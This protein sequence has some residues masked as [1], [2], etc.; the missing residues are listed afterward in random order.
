VSVPPNPF[1]TDVDP[2]HRYDALVIGAGLTGAWA[3]KELAEAGLDVLV[4]DAGPSLAPAE[5]SEVEPRT[6]PHR[7][8]AARRQPVLSQTAAWWTHPPGVPCP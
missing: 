2:H 6:S 1:L 5:V 7:R 4:L 3:A 8:D